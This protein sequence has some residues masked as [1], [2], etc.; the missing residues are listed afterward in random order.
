M[1]IHAE[2]LR[3]LY[4]DEDIYQEHRGASTDKGYPHTNLEERCVEVVAQ[5][6]K[7]RFWLEVG[8]MIGG[9]AIKAAMCLNRREE[10]CKV[11]CIDPFCGDVNMWAWERSLLLEKQWR[12]LGLKKGEPT[13][14]DRF[15]A[16]VC[17][18]GLEESICPIPTTGMVGMKLLMRLMEDGRVSARPDVVYLDA[19]HEADETLLEL[20]TAWG[21]IKSGGVL[22]GDDW[23]WDAVRFDVIR[24]A[25]QSRMDAHMSIRIRE[26]L[27]DDC[28]IAGGV[29]VWKDI[30]WFLCKP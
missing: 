11:I 17:A 28:R 19:A 25:R 5:E 1:D 10:G 8:S 20:R 14:R 24:F 22:F 13:I 3:E 7:P 30:H 23:F 4:S 15:M 9:S 27:G 2:I 21:L 12:F 16:N 26:A 18:A 29:V 6:T